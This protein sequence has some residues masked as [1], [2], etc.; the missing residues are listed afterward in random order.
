M[1][2]MA[3]ILYFE[4]RPVDSDLLKTFDNSM[5]HLGPDG[6]RTHTASSI[7]LVFRA[8]HTTHEDELESQPYSVNG[9][10][11]CFDGRLDNR[12][13]LAGLLHCND[14]GASDVCL[15]AAAYHKWNAN[16]FAQL[17]GDFCIVIWDSRTR[18]LFL[19]RDRLGIRKLFYHSNEKRIVWASAP[20]TILRCPDVPKIVDEEYV[21][22][23]LAF[24]PDGTKS[25]FRDIVPLRPGH[26]LS[27][28]GSAMSSTRF[29]SIDAISTTHN[30]SHAAAHPDR[31]ATFRSL[32]FD[33]VR[34]RLRANCPVI[35]ELS[36]GLDSSSIVCVA[37]AISNVSAGAVP[38]VQT[39]SVVFDRAWHAD[40]REFISHIERMRGRQGI[41]IKEDDDPILSRWCDS[42]FIAFPNLELCFGGLTLAKLNAMNRLGSRVLIS[43]TF[44]DHVLDCNLSAH[45]LAGLVRSLRLPS[46]LTFCFREALRLREHPLRILWK[47]GLEPNLPLWMWRTQLEIP[48]WIDPGFVKRTGLRERVRQLKRIRP[49]PTRGASFFPHLCSALNLVASGYAEC[50]TSFSCIE[51]RYPYLHIPLIEFMLSLPPTELADSYDKRRFQRVGLRDLLPEPIRTRMDKRGP[52]QASLIAIDREW[53]TLQSLLEN[54]R[55]C[56]LGYVRREELR[57]EF[58]LL[59]HGINKT[60]AVFK[61]IAV[62]RWLQALKK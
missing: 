56:E 3:G 16:C 25:P 36:G 49:D 32:F 14:V 26:F 59:R 4:D 18:C 40:E 62:E 27:V 51:M 61:F 43:G 21:S 8:F 19:A 1:S 30:R 9:I 10:T 37:D 55:A 29:W 17:Q 13:N 47:F 58:R 35:A 54:S 48:Q 23:F 60:A 46:A 11:V 57:S 2:G 6:S 42:D 45:E 38:M 28:N 12:P 34:V 52:S 31:I 22:Q 20:D 15:V 33:A 53:K 5:R 41:H 44:G 24:Y 7:G 39:L 50:Q